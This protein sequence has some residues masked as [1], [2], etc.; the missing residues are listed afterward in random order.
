MKNNQKGK[1]KE[2]GTGEGEETEK[3]M[4]ERCGFGE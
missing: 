4:G 3:V 1:G 2:R